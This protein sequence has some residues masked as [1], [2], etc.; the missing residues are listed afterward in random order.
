[1]TDELFGVGFEIRFGFQNPVQGQGGKTLRR[2]S[3]TKVG[4]HPRQKVSHPEIET[5]MKMLPLSSLFRKIYLD[6]FICSLSY[7]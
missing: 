1:L 3:W 5:E 6:F 4:G 2:C 7:Y